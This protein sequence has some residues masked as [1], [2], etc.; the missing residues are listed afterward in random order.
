MSSVIASLKRRGAVRFRAATTL[1]LPLRHAY[2]LIRRAPGRFDAVEIQ[3]VRQF[4]DTADP[5]RTCCEVDNDNPSFFSVYLHF[6]DGGVI[7]CA[8]L[9]T[10][11]EALDCAGASARRYGWPAYDYCP[12]RTRLE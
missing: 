11:Q 12:T 3:G 8:D 2:K 5:A 7:C 6:V 4:P 9:P 1:L 10:H